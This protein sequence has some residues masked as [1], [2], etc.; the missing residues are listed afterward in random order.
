MP[1]FP[2]NNIQQKSINGPIALDKAQGIVECFVAGVGNKDSV[3]DIVVSGAFTESLKRRKPRVVWG[4]N[5]ND[6]I[7]KVL[8]IYEVGPND[9]RLPEKM[10]R[11]GIGGLYAKV[12]FNLAAEK[13]REAF[14]NVAFYG[15]EQEWSIGYKT[16]QASFDPNRQANVLTE[17]ELYE[18]SP[19]LHG[20]N[21]LTGTISIKGAN[22]ALKDPKGGLT[23]AGRAHFKRTEGANL[24]P[25]VKGPADT[26]EKMRR[27]GS[28]LTR[29]FTNPSGPMKDGKG[30]PTRLA[31]SAAAWGEPVPQN[32]ADARRLAAKGRRLLERYENS[33][34][35][36]LFVDN[37]DDIIDGYG[38]FEE[39]SFDLENMDS[40][41]NC[42]EKCG[43]MNHGGPM[44]REHHNEEYGRYEEIKPL[45]S[46]GGSI[47][48]EGM[49]EELDASEFA[50]LESEL[51]RR[52]PQPI[53][54]RKAT[55]NVIWFSMGE[56][57]YLLPYHHEVPTD[58][59][60]FGKPQRMMMQQP[61]QEAPRRRF[62]TYPNQPGMDDLL[63]V[64]QKYSN[65]P[66]LSDD[67]KSLIDSSLETIEVFVSE[68]SNSGGI[69]DPDVL[70]GIK[71]LVELI[72]TTV[73]EELAPVIVKCHPRHAFE[74]KSIID[75]IANYYGAETFADETGISI[76][77]SMNDDF[78][79]AI[80]T[81]VKALGPKISSAR[82][83][84]R[85][86]TARFDRNAID[87]DEDGIVQDGTPFERPALPKTP[88]VMNPN[89]QRWSV[90]K[91]TEKI[92]AGRGGLASGAGGKRNIADAAY[93]N[94]PGGTVL[95]KIIERVENSWLKKKK[96]DRFDRADS[97]YADD[98][99]DAFKKE[100]DG[101]GND[102]DV[103]EDLLFEFKDKRKKLRTWARNENLTSDEVM[104]RDLEEVI[105]ALMDNYAMGRGEARTEAKKMLDESD[106]FVALDQALSQL[107]GEFEELRERPSTSGFAS[108]KGKRLYED[109]RPDT[110]KMPEPNAEDIL[111]EF[112]DMTSS[113]KFKKAFPGWKYDTPQMRDALAMVSGIDPVDD[114]GAPDI[115]EAL[116]YSYQLSDL[117][118]DNMGK[119]GIGFARIAEAMGDAFAWH[120]DRKGRWGGMASGKGKY[121]ES[122]DA[123]RAD[124]RNMPEP[125]AQDVLDDFDD[126]IKSPKFKKKY[127]GWAQDVQELKDALA[128]TAGLKKSGSRGKPDLEEATLRANQLAQTIEDDMGKD[129]IAFARTAQGLADAL[130]WHADRKPNNRGFASGRYD[131]DLSPRGQEIYDTQRDFEYQR[132]ADI[133]DARREARYDSIPGTPTG[134]GN[135]TK[136]KRAKTTGNEELDSVIDQ[137][138]DRIDEWNPND[139]FPSD[140]SLED[141]IREE[142]FIDL[143]A[144]EADEAM[145]S[146]RDSP[147]M[148]Y[149]IR[150]TDDYVETYPETRIDPS[151]GYMVGSVWIEDENGNEIASYSVNGPDGEG[152][153][154][155]AKTF[156]ELLKGA[157]VASKGK[158]RTGMASG[159]GKNNG[160]P[161]GNQGKKPPL[162]RTNPNSWRWDVPG[163]T[164]KIGKER[165]GLASSRGEYWDKI[166]AR[167]SDTR[168]MPEPNA[169]DVLDDFD[170]MI[171]SPEFKKQFKQQYSAWSRDLQDLK[172]ALAIASGKKKPDDRGEPDFEEA[173]LRANQLA[174]RI[175]DDM[176]KDGIGFARTAQGMAD[177][178]AWHADR[179]GVKRGFASERQMN[180]ERARRQRLDRVLSEDEMDRLIEADGTYL[181][182]L[183]DLLQPWTQNF[184]FDDEREARWNRDRGYASGRSI[185]SPARR[186]A[187]LS[188]FID[189]FGPEPDRD[190]DE[191]A[192]A[193]W[194]G[195]RRAWLFEEE[196]D[197]MRGRQ[198]PF[199]GGDNIAAAKQ[200]EEMLRAVRQRFT[201]SQA[202][203][204]FKSKNRSK[205]AEAYDRGFGEGEFRAGSAADR[206]R[207][208][209]SA[210]S[211]DDSSV[212]AELKK[213]ANLSYE[214]ERDWV[215]S[216][217]SA[218]RP[219][220][221]SG[222]WRSDDEDFIYGF[223]A[224]LTEELNKL[225]VADAG[226]ILDA[227]R[228]AM[229]K[230]AR[231]FMVD[232]NSLYAN[233]MDYYVDN[234]DVANVAKAILANPKY[235]KFLP[236]IAKD[237]EAITGEKNLSDKELSTIFAKE[238]IDI[239][240]SIK[241]TEA[242]LD[243]VE[244]SLG[245]R[246]ESELRNLDRSGLSSSVGRG[247]GKSREIYPANSGRESS[248][249]DYVRYDAAKEELTVTY[250]NGKTYTY[251][252]V[253][254]SMA[255]EVEQAGSL[256]SALADIKRNAQY[257]LRPDGT[258]NGEQPSLAKRLGNHRRRLEKSRGLDQEES[259]VFDLADRMAQGD[260]T[261]SDKETIDA[262]Q[263]IERVSNKLRA[264]DEWAAAIYL[265]EAARHAKPSRGLSSRI[266]PHRSGKMD[267]ELN[268][269]LIG[270]M[271]N[272]LQDAMR[273]Q[274]RNKTIVNGLGLLDKKLEESTDGKIS[275]SA[276][277]FNA[278][279]DAF[280]DLERIEPDG[281]G[282]RRARNILDLGAV[283]ENGKFV[284]SPKDSLDTPT[285]NGAPIDITPRIQREL[286]KWGE[287]QRGFNN[288]QKIIESHR[289][290]NGELT[291]GEWMRLQDYQENYGSRRRGFA[292]GLGDE[293]KPDLR[294]AGGRVDGARKNVA[295]RPMGTVQ[296]SKR[297][298]GR[299]WEEV[300]PDNW[301]L[302]T[303][304]ERDEALFG[305]LYPSRSGMR[306]I[307]WDRL[308]KET[309]DAI[310]KRD[311]RRTSMADRRERRR[312]NMEELAQRDRQ[313]NVVPPKP[314]SSPQTSARK[315]TTRKAAA[316][317][318]ADQLDKIKTRFEK[319]SAKFDVLESD[320]A[321]PMHGEMWNSL[322]D[323]TED[324]DD[325]T[326]SML[327]AMRDT[328]TDYLDQVDEMEAGGTELTR[329]ETASRNAAKAQLR[330]L[331]D[332]IGQYSDDDFIEQG[333]DIAPSRRVGGGFASGTSSSGSKPKQRKPKR[334]L[335][336]SE[337]E[338][339]IRNLEEQ[340]ARRNNRD[341]GSSLPPD[342]TYS[343]RERAAEAGVRRRPSSGPKRWDEIDENPLNDLN[344]T[345]GFASTGRFDDRIEEIRQSV[346]QKLIK[347][348]Q[349][350][351]QEIDD[352]LSTDQ[353]YMD[354]YK[355][356]LLDE[357]SKMDIA[358]A[359]EFLDDVERDNQYWENE[360]RIVNM[361]PSKEWADAAYLRDYD[362]LIKLLM[363]DDEFDKLFKQERRFRKEFQAANDIDMEDIKREFTKEFFARE[364]AIAMG[365]FSDSITARRLV[366]EDVKK[367]LDKRERDELD[368]LDK[369]RNDGG[370]ASG[371]DRRS[372]RNKRPISR[373]DRSLRQDRAES[374][375]SQRDAASAK[376]AME[377]AK[378]YQNARNAQSRGGFASGKAGRMEVAGEYEFF[379]QIHDSLDRE[380]R[381]ANNN[382]DS[383]TA[384]ALS[385]LRQTMT[386]QDVVKTSPKMTNARRLLLN[387]DELDEIMDALIVVLDRQMATGGSRAAMFGK[388]VDMLANSGM[389]TFID[390]DVAEIG[391]RT[392]KRTNASGRTVDV[393]IQD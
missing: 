187:S 257:T 377:A 200:R 326:M 89:S 158:K 316:K 272:G 50:R 169:Q 334:E 100:F 277:E 119:D 94:W 364:T 95:D 124:T 384:A 199:T 164:D 321:D 299:K 139:W 81:A 251:G 254:A 339:R 156:N 97:E 386:R 13:G 152:G 341:T 12:Q 372:G 366:L 53:K 184:G 32:M 21:Q 30:R 235:K 197:A 216:I 221:L 136:I 133:A 245:Q 374:R 76:H 24:K 39:K 338:A 194:Q 129:G 215:E 243:I 4:H 294:A 138:T 170:D 213:I 15:E 48:E 306:Q 383:K 64:V 55:D 354:T 242:A 141:F 86:A 261:G 310:A 78:L 211:P 352:E 17:V 344:E 285:N 328:L 373:S 115:E 315:V 36:S 379:K 286:I 331:E 74:V 345:G 20:A 6:P 9:P 171:K 351:G 236:Q 240:D 99:A 5:W 191:E 250:K 347:R 56:H 309:G 358:D 193:Y 252:G 332:L 190:E 204:L 368:A 155:S 207:G 244:E 281:H 182:D 231:K 260:F 283:D 391:S 234:G 311:E 363:E 317:Q 42:D 165:R 381:E 324:S 290:N 312:A 201:G 34:A 206:R 189:S 118:K 227:Y 308:M 46:Y 390:K 278:I 264:D 335:T 111:N 128:E 262:I 134:A 41:H 370:M 117:I 238:L 31:L 222:G 113:S 147:L 167:R 353:W 342:A 83:A 230:T 330:A 47:F 178:L 163:N 175:E 10:R 58:Q 87:G 67:A 361:A 389:A 287:Q 43:C 298:K 303:L 103:I 255:D 284:A 114:R 355:K 70:A 241:A 233:N 44:M 203:K 357:I 168:N 202:A 143:T 219:D 96:K 22:Q 142:I 23:A 159:T 116:R 107:I 19:V 305:D 25:G 110:S 359:T 319:Q 72:E 220:D 52:V 176:G 267:Y 195:A 232:A 179:K 149:R 153:G 109:R 45:S 85:F 237:H 192:F 40:W 393:N 343:Q 214:F 365:D 348:R 270:G 60:M 183:R 323:I 196:I 259:D 65:D 333:N 37:I 148:D 210:I 279:M 54:I 63:N 7:G 61:M 186:E 198:K 181:D 108:G 246:T 75:P 224:R 93:P 388:F 360:Y 288:V 249:A 90:P 130:A 273:R 313:G 350:T 66:L 289:R 382:R 38:Y 293:D 325:L 258:V 209:A 122:I 218:A 320:E 174:Q 356:A 8:E 121:W 106:Y 151:E 274:S 253:N 98:I 105:K 228:K 329:P 336:S 102:P 292:S 59:F 275:L 91:N 322:I 271:R 150:S 248:A 346:E 327:E 268:D 79:D 140:E 173:V 349:E 16:L 302:M 73:A 57:M 387:Q 125:D 375:M 49:A 62:P 263:R 269:S 68:Y 188:R 180:P 282:L 135:P 239:A 33:K 297:S 304:D 92:P 3:G 380:I 101:F 132:D 35:K 104:S 82:R 301:D 247:L 378:E 131:D 276:A 71:A 392:Q 28:F 154:D 337:S 1:S 162:K 84:A 376:R 77:G 2:S 123:R 205:F 160:K 27:K 144:E 172:D 69:P 11:A 226:D 256:G 229:Q 26:P 145:K 18:V 88:Q 120:S 14:T 177:A 112:D 385:T 280:G 307:D 266:A 127:P 295:G 225:G 137:V 146:F 157:Y 217:A 340:R 369:R 166:D 51:V 208:L 29:F 161:A 371:S 80:D 318:R 223:A 314:A 296:E 185:D 212:P 362:K 265:D 367:A 291:V 126:M 300:K